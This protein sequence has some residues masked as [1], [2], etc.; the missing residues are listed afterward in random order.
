M[1]PP[2]IQIWNMAGNNKT[3][4]AQIKCPFNMLVAG[5]TQSGKTTWVTHLL[6]HANDL[7]ETPPSSVHWYSPHSTP[8]H[9]HSSL[10]FPLFHHG[11]QL[12]WG[13]VKEDDDE[14]NEEDEEKKVHLPSEGDVI[15]IDDFAQEMV[16]SRDLTNFL[17]KHSHHRNISL[18]VLSQNLFWAGKETRT[19]SLNYHYICLMRQSRDYK[20]IRTLGR[21]LTQKENEYRAFLEAYNEATNSR[22]FAYLLISMHPRDD[23]RLLL[24]STIFPEEATASTVYLLKKYKRDE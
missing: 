1:S 5:P 20:Q 22:L 14:I 4:D 16:N 11:N 13:K 8:P 18:I 2:V 10:P 23:K 3:I 15:V 9:I 19:Q 21:Q 7:L 24:R 17:S 12:P 6:Y